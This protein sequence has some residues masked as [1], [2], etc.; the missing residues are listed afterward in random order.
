[1]LAT[2]VSGTHVLVWRR[3][4]QGTVRGPVL[5]PIF[6]NIIHEVIQA[7]NICL[8]AADTSL[9][10]SSSNNF[11]LE[12]KAFFEANNL[13]KWFNSNLISIN[14]NQTQLLHFSISNKYNSQDP[15]LLLSGHLLETTD[16][17]KFLGIHLDKDKA[18]RHSFF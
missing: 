18:K 1:M 10:V 17:V 11:E 9:S 3:S 16:H 4:P 5:F 14:V 8:F 12:L 15:V 7:G 2:D 6:I 13:L